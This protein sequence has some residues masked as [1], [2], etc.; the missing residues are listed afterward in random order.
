I[1]K[2][3]A[4]TSGLVEF[5]LDWSSAPYQ[6]ALADLRGRVDVDLKNGRILSIEPGFG[7]VLGVLAV[8]QW[9]KRIQ[10]DFS[11]VYGEGMTFNSIT[12]HFDLVNGKAITKDLIVDAV[13]AKI[14]IT[15]ETDL[16]NRAGEHIINVTPKSADA[17]PIAGTIMG[18]VMALVGQT[19]TGKNQEGFFFGSQYLVKGAW[20]NAQIIPL[21]ENDGLLQKT[22]NGLTDFSWLQQQNN[23]QEKQHD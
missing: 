17:V 20:S 6:F 21:H 1:T 13:P 8:A 7:R 3:F 22:W 16:V 10:L 23:Q 4:E 14:T 19:L 18:K 5:K 11:D 12:G 2:D 9:L 15:G